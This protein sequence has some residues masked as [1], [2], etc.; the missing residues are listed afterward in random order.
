MIDHDAS[1]SLKRKGFSDQRWQCCYGRS[2]EAVRDHRHSLGIRPVY[3]RVDTCAAEFAQPLPI[4]I[5]LTKRSARPSL[6]RKE[7][8]GAWWRPNRIGQGIEFDY[9][10]VHAAWPCVKMVMK[11]SW[12]TVIQK[13]SLPT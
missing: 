13:P 2:E 7:N 6:G 5:P 1:V 4:C 8:Y 10:C 11:P 3:K 9:C 12:L